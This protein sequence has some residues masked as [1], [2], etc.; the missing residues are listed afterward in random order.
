MASENLATVAKR[1]PTLL[2]KMRTAAADN[3]SAAVQADALSYGCETFTLLVDVLSRAESELSTVAK[4]ALGFLVTPTQREFLAAEDKVLTNLGLESEEIAKAREALETL[5]N[6]GQLRDLEIDKDQVLAL[7]KSVRD[8][9]CEAA[10]FSG[11][12]TRRLKKETMAAYADATLDVC[13]ISGN[14]LAVPAAIPTGPIGVVAAG[15]LAVA[16]VGAG[17]KGLRKKV[18]KLFGFLAAEKK[19]QAE[20]EA[21]KKSQEMLQKNRRD[22]K[23]RKDKDS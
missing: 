14:L 2:L 1:L 15:L 7:L 3:A 20:S 21:A 9:T 4:A 16:S 5:S 12:K 11:A 13:L 22:F 10:K 18:D 6:D 8:C 23:L 17:V 19:D